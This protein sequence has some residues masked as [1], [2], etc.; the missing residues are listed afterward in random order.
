MKESLHTKGVESQL[1]EMKFA[2]E[3][4]KLSKDLAETFKTGFFKVQYD[5]FCKKM[6][7]EAQQ[8]TEK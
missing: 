3:I 1:T 5:E 8:L 2:E 4:N 6:N 7:N